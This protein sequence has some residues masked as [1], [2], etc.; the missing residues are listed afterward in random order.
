M[1]RGG[2]SGH[3]SYDL[4][5]K[6]AACRLVEQENYSVSEAAT[7]LGIP[8]QTLSNWLGRRKQQAPLSKD[9][10]VLQARVRELEKQLKRSETEK[11]ILKKAAAFFIS[12]NP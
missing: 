4:Q 10:N 11:E 8:K 12:Q 5:F 9:V 6:E 3:R 1:G 2:S 7:E